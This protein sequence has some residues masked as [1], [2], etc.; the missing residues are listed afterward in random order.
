LHHS[1]YWSAR[2]RHVV[3]SLPLPAASKN[4]PTYGAGVGPPPVQP[5]SKRLVP[6]KQGSMPPPTPFTPGGPTGPGFAALAHAD[7]V[8]MQEEFVVVVV[9]V[10]EVAFGAK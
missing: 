9:A 5:P 6:G 3:A 10:G 2:D 7:W 1:A 4:V 8:I